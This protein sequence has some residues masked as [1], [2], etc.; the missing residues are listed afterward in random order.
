M[1]SIGTVLKAAR[2][3]KSISFDEVYS[4][5]KIHPRVLARLESDTFDNLPSLFVK[6]F[7]RSYASFLEV[8]A[9]PLLDAYHQR[10][11]G[12]VEPARETSVAQPAE[13]P[14]HLF[15]E[16]PYEPAPFVWPED[17][18]SRQ[19]L[20]T[21]RR[22]GVVASLL[23]AVS[24]YFMY[25]AVKTLR[26]KPRTVAGN[27][28]HSAGVMPPLKEM[29]KPEPAAPGN[30]ATAKA[31]PA[32]QPTLETRPTTES[33]AAAAAAKAIPSARLRIS[34]NGKVVYEGSLNGGPARAAVDGWTAGAS[35][36]VSPGLSS[37]ALEA[38][39]KGVVRRVWI[40]LSGSC[41]KT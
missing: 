15:Q 9:Q 34:C 7:L 17:R 1:S 39:G 14:A 4:T 32:P 19:Q 41:Q 35:S 5:T 25:P 2:Q 33:I 6:N 8:D 10:D 23:I 21:L 31:S 36:S 28:L 22:L 24:L 3:A 11:E 16:S 37:Y 27:A 40:R 20:L 30:S 29:A 12:A 13:A 26:A 18:S 38:V